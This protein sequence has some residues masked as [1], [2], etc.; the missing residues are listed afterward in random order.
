[1]SST[2][3]SSGI[4]SDT[5]SSPSVRSASA[6]CAKLSLLSSLLK[7]KIIYPSQ[8]R[9]IPRMN[10]TIRQSMLVKTKV[11]LACTS[12]ARTSMPCPIRTRLVNPNAT[13]SLYQNQLSVT[14]H[15]RHE[16][17][18]MTVRKDPPLTLCTAR[19]SNK[20]VPLSDGS[21]CV[22]YH[23]RPLQEA[24]IELICSNEVTFVFQTHPPLASQKIGMK[25]VKQ[26]NR[27][28]RSLSGTRWMPRC[29]SADFPSYI[30]R[31]QWPHQWRWTPP[32]G[33]RRSCTQQL[34]RNLGFEPTGLYDDS[35]SFSLYSHR[36]DDMFDY[37]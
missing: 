10:R 9:R 14:I 16:I 35:D 5:D 33:I 31:A 15:T 18:T 6:S 23:D 12:P 24:N 1:M 21:I 17:H 8:I 2:A 26:S 34:H 22:S 13:N 36:R 27:T 19:Q 20:K 25:N 29:A 11:S 28:V 7:K 32:L 30:R 37:Y 3:S 4:E